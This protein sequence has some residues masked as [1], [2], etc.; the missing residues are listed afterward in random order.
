LRIIKVEVLPDEGGVR[1]TWESVTDRSYRVERASMLAGPFE[2][3]AQGIV[4]GGE[5]TSYR[6]EGEAAVESYFLRVK[7]EP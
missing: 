7:L 2:G 5:E 6:I 1:L 4:S 3:V